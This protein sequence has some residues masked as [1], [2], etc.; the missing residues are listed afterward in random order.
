LVFQIKIIFLSQIVSL[1]PR[2][3]NIPIASLEEELEKTAKKNFS[4]E[5][6]MSGG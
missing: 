2:K 4:N 6:D 1:E 3:V 5:K